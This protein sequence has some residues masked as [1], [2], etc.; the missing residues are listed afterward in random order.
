MLTVKNNNSNN[1][2]E[3]HKVKSKSL[4]PSPIL[5]GNNYQQFWGHRLS[6]A[7]TSIYLI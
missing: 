3:E 7:C 2:L 6:C 5:S 1:L 4:P